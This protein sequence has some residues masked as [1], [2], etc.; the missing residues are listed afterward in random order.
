MDL[1]LPHATQHAAHL[2]N[3]LEF[4]ARAPLTSPFFLYRD[5]LKEK[6]I[7]KHSITHV[8]SISVN[9]N[10]CSEQNLLS[11]IEITGS[12]F[13][14]LPGGDTSRWRRHIIVLSV[15]NRVDQ[16]LRCSFVRHFLNS[17]L[18]NML[19]KLEYHLNRRSASFEPM[20]VKRSVLTFLRYIICNQ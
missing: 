17:V 12:S 7:T 5:I 8:C 16:K 2:A 6:E 13:E 4:F 11:Y 20:P 19:I 1:N 3:A 14:K 9:V 10:I 15:N 18:F